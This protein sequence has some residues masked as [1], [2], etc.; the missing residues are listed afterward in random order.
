MISKE[1]LEEF[2]NIYKKRF[3]KTLSDQDAIEKGTKLLRLVE[4]VYKPITQKEYDALQKR[5]KETDDI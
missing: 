4:I 5:R 1:K 2:K 3:N